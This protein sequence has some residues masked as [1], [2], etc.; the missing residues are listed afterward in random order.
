MTVNNDEKPIFLHDDVL[1]R[2]LS[3]G[4]GNVLLFY[5]VC[6]YLFRTFYCQQFDTKMNIFAQKL[7]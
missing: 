6:I 4:I 5:L 7:R 3:Y 2:N 1:Y